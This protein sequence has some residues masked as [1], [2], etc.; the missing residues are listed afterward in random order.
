M[1]AGATV[2]EAA[3]ALRPLL[4]SLAYRMVGSMSEAEDLVQEAFLR[5]HRARTEGTEIESTKAFLTTVTTRLGIDHLRSARVRREA[6]VGP[7]FPDPFVDELAP[8]VASHAEMADSLSMA[9]LLVLETLSPAE[10]AV[11][12]LRE[13]FDYDYDEIA[14]IIDKSPANCRQLLVRARRR[15]DEGKPRF[16]ASREERDALAERFYAS[17]EDGDLDGLIELLAA[18]V[19]FTGDGGGKANAYARAIVGPQRVA[20]LLS[21]LFRKTREHGGSLR[22]VHVGGLPGVM[23]YDNDERVVAVWALD[24]ADGQVQTIRGVV[25]PDKL[26]HLGPVSDVNLKRRPDAI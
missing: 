4:L 23:V 11:F 19:S 10:R 12:L 22:L 14:E 21:G 18:D 8:D 6:Y 3:A 13:V 9:F 17:C 7:W 15:I 20:K 25:N 26:A 24:V 1:T 16:E 2:D 5:L